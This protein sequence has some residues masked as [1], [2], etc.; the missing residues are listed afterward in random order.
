MTA[1]KGLHD[2][3]CV[4]KSIRAIGR[5]V[6]PRQVCRAQTF[7]QFSGR[8]IFSIIYKKMSKADAIMIAGTE[9]WRFIS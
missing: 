2:A 8:Y 9:E 3:K 5:A 1:I 7:L 6:S 4:I